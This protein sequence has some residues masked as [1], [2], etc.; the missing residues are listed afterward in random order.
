MCTATESELHVYFCIY[1]LGGANQ[2]LQSQR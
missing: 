2:R 1:N